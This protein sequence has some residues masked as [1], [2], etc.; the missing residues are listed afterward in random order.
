MTAPA[1]AP[2]VNADPAEVGKFDALASRWWD[3]QGEFAPL[4]RLNPVRLAYITARAALDGEPVL[5][6]GC[7]GGILSESLARAGARVLGIDLAREALATARLHALGE[8][9]SVEYQE[10]SAEALAAE[11][12]GGFAVVTCMEMLEHVPDP[13]SVVGAL[14]RLIRPGGS[15]FVSTINRG[16]RAFFGA[17]VAGEY[18]LSLLPRGTHQYARFIRPSELARAARAAGLVVEDLAGVV[19]VP[20]SREFRLSADVG[21]NY[22][23]HLRRPGAA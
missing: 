8:G 3:P 6:V 22:L 5:D 23:M 11:R 17:I 14:A 13:G 4:H 7:G 2:A 19:P 16:A 9:L 12:P 21:I 20:F 18:L 10:R 1:A 15:V